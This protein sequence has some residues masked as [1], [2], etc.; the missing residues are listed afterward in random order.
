MILVHQSP[1]IKSLM[2]H[3]CHII[4]KANILHCENHM[5]R[6]IVNISGG[7]IINEHDALRIIGI[8]MDEIKGILT[9]GSIQF[10]QSYIK[11]L[12]ISA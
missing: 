12:L 5:K 2:N 11:L 1:T 6:D 9:T 3:S 7:N 10:C 8:F 4:I